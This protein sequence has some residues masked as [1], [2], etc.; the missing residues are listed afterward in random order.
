MAYADAAKAGVGIDPD[1]RAYHMLT[2]SGVTRSITLTVSCTIPRLSDQGHL[3]TL[4]RFKKLH[5]DFTTNLGMWTD[6]VT[7]ER[8]W[9]G[10]HDL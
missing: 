6:T 8:L 3:W 9:A 4:E 7:Q 1:R 10:T 2:R 5:S